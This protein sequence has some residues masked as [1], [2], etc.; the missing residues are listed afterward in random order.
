MADY[1]GSNYVVSDNPLVSGFLENSGV[2][3]SI[4]TTYYKMMAYD[5][6]VN[7]WRSW[8]A[9]NSPDLTASQYRAAPFPFTQ[10]FVVGIWR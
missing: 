3:Y 7:L 5:T 10:V 2:T 4:N 6:S 8:V 1:D 9:S